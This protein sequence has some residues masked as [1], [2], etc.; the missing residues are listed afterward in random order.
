MGRLCG[1][2]L[3]TS[4][5]PTVL[6]AYLLKEL[7]VPAP[8]I[9]TVLNELNGRGT[10]PSTV[11]IQLSNKLRPRPTSRHSHVLTR[12]KNAND[13]KFATQNARRQ[14]FLRRH[15]KYQSK[16]TTTIAEPTLRVW[17]TTSPSM[18]QTYWSKATPTHTT[19]RRNTC[20]TTTSCGAYLVQTQITNDY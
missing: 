11:P 2:K 12:R 9:S 5:V 6:E 7:E 16:T 10:Q 4:R 17:A 1:T 18:P 14:A 19:I 8:I 20:S 13:R 15:G 3:L